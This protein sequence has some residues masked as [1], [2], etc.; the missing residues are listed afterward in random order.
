M[1]AKPTLAPAVNSRAGE[2]FAKRVALCKRGMG[3]SYRF[4]PSQRV[5]PLQR[6]PHYIPE[7]LIK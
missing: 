4:H 3:A 7:S 2:L 5:K 6:L 1:P